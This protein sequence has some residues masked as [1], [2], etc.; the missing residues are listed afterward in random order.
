MTLTLILAIE[1]KNIPLHILSDVLLTGSSK[2]A[3]NA[4]LPHIRK[5]KKFIYG[6]RS[7]AALVQKTVLIENTAFAWAGR[8]IVARSVFRSFLDKSKGGKFYT[9]LTPIIEEL[10]L[11]DE[12]MSSISII[13]YH[14]N[15]N[16]ITSNGYNMET[17]Q[18][19]GSQSK[20]L[21]SGTGTWDFL[22]NYHTRV[23]KNA[24]IDALQDVVQRM[25]V[26][27]AE[28]WV[29]EEKTLNM[30]YGSWFELTQA[31]NG[32][33][34]KIP[35]AYKFWTKTPQNVVFSPYGPLVFSNYYENDMMIFSAHHDFENEKASISSLLLGDLA[36]R[37]RSS[38]ACIRKK[39]FSEMNFSP[40]LFIHILLQYHEGKAKMQILPFFI[41]GDPLVRFS[42]V[43]NSDFDKFDITY[44]KELIDMINTPSNFIEV[45]VYNP[46]DD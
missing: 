32:V 6:D 21:A 35:I 12:E 2:H 37:S 39:A 5:P 15:N 40:E 19:E 28:P 20:I 13:T 17:Y 3:Q 22:E 7:I 31:V 45:E 16:K 23:A 14:Y 4:L 1:D 41:T 27:F 46:W 26:R 36:G 8:S 25:A 24:K 10:N 18:K 34:K 29:F 44:D 30:A 42:H 11:T 9:P 33:F 38:P 43:K